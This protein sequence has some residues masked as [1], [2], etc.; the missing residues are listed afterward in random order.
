MFC[1]YEVR[2]APFDPATD[3]PPKYNRFQRALAHRAIHQER[4][5]AF[6]GPRPLKEDA[7]V[8]LY[9]FKVQMTSYGAP[10]ADSYL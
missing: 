4:A 5:A 2:L 6:Y 8:N 3:L 1:Q 10:G 9:G 7:Y